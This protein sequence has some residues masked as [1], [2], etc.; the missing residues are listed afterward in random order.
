MTRQA[1]VQALINIYQERGNSL[2]DI[3]GDPIFS[4]LPI[5]KQVAAIKTYGKIIQDGSHAPNTLKTVGKSILWGLA[6]GAIAGLPYLTQGLGRNEAIGRSVGVMISGGA[7]GSIIGAFK[8][9][10]DHTSYRDTNTHLSKVNA[11]GLEEAIRAIMAKR[12]S[13]KTPI[14]AMLAGVK[15]PV[16]EVLDHTKP[17]RDSF[18]SPN[19]E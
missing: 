9:R 13:H 10:S 1:E 8:A 16:K 15:G 18:Q 12:D 4:S 11:G 3:L 7:V 19:F 14:E 6:T 17:I 5:D 2:Q